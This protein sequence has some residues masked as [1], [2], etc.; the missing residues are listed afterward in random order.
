MNNLPTQIATLGVLVP[1]FYYTERITKNDC[2]YVRPSMLMSL[3]LLAIMYYTKT[4]MPLPIFA[5]MIIGYICHINY[6]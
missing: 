5:I 3:I 1:I 2:N 4:E 6:C